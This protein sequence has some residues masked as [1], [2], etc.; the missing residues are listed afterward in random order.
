M[1]RDAGVLGRALQW[2]PWAAGE[3]LGFPLLGGWLRRWLRE[4][5]SCGWRKIEENQRFSS[6]EKGK[7][8]GISSC[9]LLNYLLASH[10]VCFNDWLLLTMIHREAKS[11]VLFMNIPKSKASAETYA[12]ANINIA[13]AHTCQNQLS[14]HHTV[15]GHAPHSHIS[16]I[17]QSKRPKVRMELLNGFWS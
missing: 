1:H 9:A 12:W 3:S 14:T 10:K 17:L 16:M 4:K 7:V 5:Q 15:S 2:D 8:C 6:R 11:S 13:F